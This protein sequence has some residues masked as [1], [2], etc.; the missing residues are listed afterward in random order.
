MNLT[1]AGKAHNGL[2][3]KSGEH[4]VSGYVSSSLNLSLRDGRETN[5]TSDRYHKASQ[6]EYKILTT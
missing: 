3:M 5:I 2:L 1:Q 4:V 6:N